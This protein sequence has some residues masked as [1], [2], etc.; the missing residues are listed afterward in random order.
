MAVLQD[1][2]CPNCDGVVSFDSGSQTVKCPFCESEFDPNAFMTL[3]A[4][5]KKEAQE[6]EPVWEDTSGSE[7]AEGEAERMRVYACN[8]CG[9]EILADETTAATTCP[10]CDSTVVMKGQLAGDLRPDYLIPFRITKEQAKAALKAHMKGKFLAPK[11]FKDENHLD[12]IKGLYV[13]FWLFSADV[14]ASIHYRATDVHRYE[15]PSASVREVRHY[16]VLR[17][18]TVSFSHIPVDGSE[19]MPDDLMESIEPYDFKDAQAF[20]AVYLAG[21]L[22]DRYDVD[23]EQSKERANVRIR[24]TTE[25]A[26]RSTLSRY[27]TVTVEQS[28]IALS[29]GKTNYVLY[30]VW[31]L[32]TSWRDKRYTFAMNGQ[33][34]K[35]VGDL[36][37]D[38]KRAFWL[39]AGL[40]ALFSALS[41]GVMLLLRFGGII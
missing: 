35:F 41:Y 39:G 20:N 18:G 24:R 4:E 8:S 7:W 17:G 40:T 16:A 23:A 26:F 30:P 36:P 15:T 1:F 33:T 6:Q 19:K 29:G 27:E 25:D 11:A 12:E 14:A 28:N 3:D 22:A 32:N 5:L 9:G 34:G 10:Y 38:K 13:P 31:L 2:K 37:I 21:F